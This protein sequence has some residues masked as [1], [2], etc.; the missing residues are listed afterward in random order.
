MRSLSLLSLLVT[1]SG[2]GVFF[3]VHAPATYAH[4]TVQV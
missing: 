3:R 2:C 1:L 4:A